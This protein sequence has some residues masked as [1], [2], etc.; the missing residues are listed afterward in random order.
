MYVG[1]FWLE[2]SINNP[3]QNCTYEKTEEGRNRYDALY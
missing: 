1:I 3:S 2:I